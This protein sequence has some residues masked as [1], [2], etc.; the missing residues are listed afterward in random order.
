MYLQKAP[1]TFRAAPAE[2]Q[3]HC[4]VIGL[5]WTLGHWTIY[6]IGFFFFLRVP[7]VFINFF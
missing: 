2:I 7:S 1:D 6:N 4:I 3:T 5:V